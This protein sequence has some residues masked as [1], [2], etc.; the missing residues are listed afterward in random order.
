MSCGL[1]VAD[2]PKCGWENRPLQSCLL[3]ASWAPG[4]PLVTADWQTQSIHVPLSLGWQC[5][6]REGTESGYGTLETI[7][8][9][10]LRCGDICVRG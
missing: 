3:P 4:A 7:H 5:S 10:R 6:H 9:Q 8:E 2:R 1:G